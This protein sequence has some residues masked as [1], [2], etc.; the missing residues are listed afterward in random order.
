MHW[1]TWYFWL[2]LFVPPLINWSLLDFFQGKRF[3]THQHKILFQPFFSLWFIISLVCSTWILFCS[4]CFVIST[5]PG[6][7]EVRVVHHQDVNKRILIALVVASTLLGGILLF[8]SCFW[9]QRQRSL[10][11]SGRKSQQNLGI[12]FSQAFHVFI[13]YD[14]VTV[15]T[16]LFL[17][18]FLFSCF[19]LIWRCC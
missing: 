6:M 8:L 17:I 15:F 13:F 2:N 9:I 3:W 18:L 7:P 12:L 5:V 19:V 4:H 1:R 10:R 14:G 16:P 11:N